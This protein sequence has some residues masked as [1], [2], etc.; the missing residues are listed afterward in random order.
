MRGLS[1]SMVSF[2]II[3]EDEDEAL[4]C[5]EVLL[6]LILD[7]GT[8]GKLRQGGEHTVEEYENRA[9]A[10]GE[11]VAVAISIRGGNVM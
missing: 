2:S 7:L 4:S 5:S 3:G 11:T 6:G 10:D 8:R 1:A 9:M